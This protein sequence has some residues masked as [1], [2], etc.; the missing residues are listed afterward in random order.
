LAEAN[1]H[2]ELGAFALGLLDPDER[3]TFERHLADCPHCS[4]ELRTLEEALALV[5]L[6]AP[7]FELP[8]A[9]ERRTFVAVE[10]AAAA[11]ALPRHGRRS[12]RRRVALVSAVAAAAAAALV[13]GLRSAP[14]P[15]ELEVRTVLRAARGA[16]HA[17][18]DV[19][20]TGIGRVV[21]FH[22]DTLPI[23]PKGEYYEL[24]FVGP[25]DRPG[26]PNRISAGTFHPDLDGR[27]TLALTAAVD[28][29]LYPV[30]VVTAEHGDGDPRSNGRE[31]LRSRG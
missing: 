3:R 6:A 19:R 20:K 1:G 27:S 9:L 30:L 22:S 13:L 28:P 17:S 2:A 5:Q 4:S 24:W 14:S 18:V 16:A 7:S 31:V 12:R 11:T 15:G 29:V 8:A 10:R 21:T 26:R 25:G 23:L